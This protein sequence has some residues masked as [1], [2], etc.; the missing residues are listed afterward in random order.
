MKTFKKIIFSTFLFLIFFALSI[1]IAKA[2]EF[3]PNIPIPGTEFATDVNFEETTGTY[4]IARYVIAIYNYGI[5]IGAILATVVLMAAGLM[6]LTSGGSQEKIGQA[7]N[8]ISGSIIGLVLLFGS[9]TI[10]NM[11]NPELVNFRTTDIP[12]IGGLAQASYCNKMIGEKT[13]I[14]TDNIKVIDGKVHNI[15]EEKIIGEICTEDEICELE[16]IETGSSPHHV[17]PEYKCFIVGCCHKSATYPKCWNRTEQYCPPPGEDDNIYYWG[18][19]EKCRQA[20]QA[21]GAPTCVPK[22]E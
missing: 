12:N 2:V 9:Y 10:L 1:Q 11:V 8:M 19:D 16:N 20:T 15:E 7:K 14:F 18:K 6:W 3:K 13:E 22:E 17:N 4:Y 21:G 5:S